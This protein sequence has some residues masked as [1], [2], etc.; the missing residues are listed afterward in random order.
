MKPRQLLCALSIFFLFL[1][2]CSKEAK[3]DFSFELLDIKTDQESENIVLQKIDNTYYARLPL[4]NDLSQLAL[5]WNDKDAIVSLNDSIQSNDFTI[6]DF[7]KPIVAKI[8]TSE[9][10]EEYKICIYHDTG[11]PVLYIDIDDS[12]IRDIIK[13]D[14]LGGNSLLLDDINNKVVVEK[15]KIRGRGNSTWKAPKKPFQIKFP[16]RTAMLGMPE[17]KRWILLAEYSDK[18]MLRNHAAFH[19]SNISKLE[20]TPQGE[21]VDLIVN[22]EFQGLYHL[23]QKVEDYDDR[24]ELSDDGYL[25]EVDQLGRLDIEDT[26]CETDTFLFNIYSPEIEFN[27]EKYDYINEYLNDAENTLRFGDYKDSIDGY[28]KYFD[29]D[30]F[31]D[32]YLITEITKNTDSKFHSSVYL[33]LEKGEKLKMGPIWDF[34]LAFGNVDYNTNWNPQGF[35]IMKSVWFKKLMYH[36][37]FKNAVRDRFQYFYDHRQDLYLEIRQKSLYLATSQKLNDEKWNLIG[38]Y[39][40]P[41]YAVYE[42]YEE[43]VEKLIEWLEQRFQW[44]KVS[45]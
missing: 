12:Q 3:E 5:T 18:T 31:I 27:D 39:V 22:G 33:T 20:W 32:W 16:R 29:M 7:T 17:A 10:I 34:D 14:Y 6:Y 25:L 41:N 38:N 8:A 28:L 40:W 23:T 9:K 35:W 15:V 42:N 4:E 1:L 2:G 44:I 30:S 21:F 13:E 19:L 43:E 36:D 24:V 26:Y 11:L 37:N 45:L